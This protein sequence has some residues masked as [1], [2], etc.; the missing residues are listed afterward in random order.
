M[1]VVLCA[2]NLSQQINKSPIPSRKGLQQATLPA[3][4][5]ARAFGR[6]ACSA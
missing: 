6:Q 5:H 2:P 4:A 3:A 1:R